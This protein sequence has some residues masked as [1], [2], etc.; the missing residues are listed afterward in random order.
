LGI[1]LSRYLWIFGEDRVLFPKVA[2]EVADIGGYDDYACYKEA[3]YKCHTD[4][5]RTEI[6]DAFHNPSV[7]LKCMGKP[8]ILNLLK[9]LLL[10]EER[11]LAASSRLYGLDGLATF[12][13]NPIKSIGILS[14]CRC[15]RFRRD[16]STIPSVQPV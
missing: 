3:Q 14:S 1:R 13:A 16:R 2:D 5:E 4:P 9:K 15:L 8:F 11:N 12:V 6:K 10:Y 7:I